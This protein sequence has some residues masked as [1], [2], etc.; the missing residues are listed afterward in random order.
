MFLFFFLLIK[1]DTYSI[2]INTSRGFHNY[3]HM[4]DL[5]IMYDLLRLYST[6]SSNIITY[7]PEDI[8]QDKRNLVPETVHVNEKEKLKYKKLTSKGYTVND[9]L[10]GL[11]CNINEL[12]NITCKDNIFIYMVGHGCD[13][14]IKFYD[15]EWL[16]KEDLMRSLRILSKRVNK[17]FFILDTC[18]AESIISRDIKNMYLVT[19]S[20]HGEPS[21][22]VSKSDTLGVYTADELSYYFMRELQNENSENYTLDKIF[23]EISYDMTSTL[24][25]KK[26]ESFKVKDFFKTK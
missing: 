9:V 5:Y 24:T 26:N 13:G 14:A 11:R 3:R 21:L 8:F 22:S 17:I 6:P 4:T 12:K 25:W 18:E 23:E 7:F 20:V 15:K 1:S 10:N 2:L 19:T 16:T